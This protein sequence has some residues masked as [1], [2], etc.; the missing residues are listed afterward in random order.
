[1]SQAAD[2]AFEGFWKYWQS[3]SR[4]EEVTRSEAE[5]LF[6]AGHKAAAIQASNVCKA[7]AAVEERSLAIQQ[8]GEKCAM[9]IEH[10]LL[11][12]VQP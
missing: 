7:R 12:K 2:Q 5:F 11:G 3:D 8:E 6:M 9:Q 1:M 10:T 4:I